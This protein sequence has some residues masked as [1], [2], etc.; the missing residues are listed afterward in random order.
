M[1]KYIQNGDVIDVTLA[2]A[3]TQDTPGALGA[4]GGVYLA[5][6]VTGAVVPFAC[7]GVFS[8]PKA[9]GVGL[10]AG[11]AVGVLSGE[12]QAAAAT[13]AVALGHATAAAATGDATVNVRLATF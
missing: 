7:K 6:G 3:A 11:A 5:S 10:A 1:S 4:L 13:G 9:S 2:A 8:L 12:V